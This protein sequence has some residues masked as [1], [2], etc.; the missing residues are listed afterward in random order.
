MKGLLAGKRIVVV[1]GTTG[2]GLSAVKAFLAED[3]FVAAFGRTPASVAEAQKS[4]GSSAL[5]FAAD[6]TDPRSTAEAI[7]QCVRRF[8]GFDGLYHVAGGSG[9]RFG[10]GPL[11][12]VTN[13]GWAETLRLNLTSVAY[14][15]R[16]AIRQF[17]RQGGGGTLL[18]TS[19]VLGFSPSPRHFATHA[20]AAAKAA[21][22]GLTQS[23][24]SCYAPDNIRVNALAP[25]L[26]ETPMAQRAVHTPAVLEFVRT[27]QPLDGGRVGQPTDVDA[28]AVYFMSDASRFV[29]GQILAIDGGWSVSEGQ[30]A[31]ASPGP[32]PD[33]RETGDAP[34]SE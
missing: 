25:A 31:P 7:E 18:N 5:L 20:Y 12:E 11:H 3:A 30:Y 14:S 26:V 22:L 15:N 2:L 28:A 27:K 23:L 4:V 34:P 16:A 9:R 24:A 1:G 8:G 10:D 19:S 21:I 13:E 33:A 6:A 17:L 29:T 32:G